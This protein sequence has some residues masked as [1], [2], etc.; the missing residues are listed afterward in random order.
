MVPL[1]AAA[2][3]LAGWAYDK[4]GSY[5]GAIIGSMVALALATAAILMLPKP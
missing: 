1:T 2:S 3:P 5:D 4:T